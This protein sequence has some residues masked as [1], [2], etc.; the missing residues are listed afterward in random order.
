MAILQ[1][2]LVLGVF[3]ALGILSLVVIWSHFTIQPTFNKPLN[4]GKPFPGDSHTNLLHFAQVRLFRLL[5]MKFCKKICF[6]FTK[7]KLFI[8]VYL[9]KFL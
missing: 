9:F 6:Y 2:C 8:I 4:R 7:F 3:G 1:K 5:L